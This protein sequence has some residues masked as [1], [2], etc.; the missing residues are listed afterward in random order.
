MVCTT[1]KPIKP[2]RIANIT[3]TI[4]INYMIQFKMIANLAELKLAYKIKEIDRWHRK[5]INLVP[6]IPLLVIHK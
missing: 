2:P 6:K 4:T 1:P 5:K 3:I